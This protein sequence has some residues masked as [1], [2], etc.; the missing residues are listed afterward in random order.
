MVRLHGGG[1]LIVTEEEAA[2]MAENEDLGGYP[3][4]ADC[5]RR[6]PEVKPYAVRAKTPTRKQLEAT[7]LARD[8][9]AQRALNDELGVAFNGMG[10]DEQ[11]T[12]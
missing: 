10:N 1:L 4:G 9:A 7:A 11:A 5:L 8:E 3:I 2:T 12:E 6:H